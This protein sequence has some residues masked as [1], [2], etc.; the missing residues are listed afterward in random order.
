MEQRL[1]SAGLILI[2]A[3]CAGEPTSTEPTVTASDA[4]A[5]LTSLTVVDLGS[6]GGTGGEALAV[7]DSGQVVGFSETSS[8]Q[9]HAFLWKNGTM[10]D[11][12]TLGG[13]NSTAF[14]INAAG[15]VVGF[16][17]TSSGE[18]HAFLWEQGVMKDLGT[19]GGT[20][21]EAHGINDSGQVVGRSDTPTGVMRAFIWEKGVM[22]KLP[23]IDKTFAYA[24][25]INNV[26]AVVGYY[27][28]K[29]VGN[30]AFRLKGTALTDL[31]T[32]GGKNSSALAINNSRIVGTAQGPGG[33]RAF[34]WQGG[35]MTS[36]GISGKSSTANA[37][38][39]SGQI[40]GYVLKSD[41][42]YHGFQWTNGT[43]SDLG[44]GAG[45]GIN[46][47]GWIAGTRVV[48]EISHPTLWKPK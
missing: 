44:A 41:N 7:N 38:N 10:Q 45:N 40:V 37:V 13:D 5:S 24:A 39:A 21:S 17:S 23:V 35:V 36:L 32:L 12:G 11:L 9:N 18:V 27:R 1:L 19:L 6:L 16:S 3:G 31:G 43:V 22:K 15:Q 33:Y 8:R 25:G 28:V 30:H 29:G 2:L 26:G 20:Y 42:V 14:A 47:S 4:A 48:N 46:G 34:V